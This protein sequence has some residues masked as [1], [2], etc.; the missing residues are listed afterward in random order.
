MPVKELQARLEI[1]TRV[2]ADVPKEDRWRAA[3]NVVAAHTVRTFGVTEGE[4]AILLKTDDGIHLKFVYPP[5]LGAGA[6]VFP[7]ASASVAGAVVK[8]SRGVVDN[9]F[10][11]TKHLGFYELARLEVPKVGPIQKMVAAP[12][13]GAG[14]VFGVI[15]VS[16]KG[17]D[18]A[19]AGPDFTAQD[20]LVLT[21][22]GAAV[23]PYLLQ[24]R[25]TLH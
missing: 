1:L 21:E 14:P 12:V 8:A 11:Q 16:R 25:P 15:E 20:L 18:P 9:A 2:K 6:N 22:I 7:I 17:A 19:A 10:A 23:G 3:L 13:L 4:V 5:A 24:L